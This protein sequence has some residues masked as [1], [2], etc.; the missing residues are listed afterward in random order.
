MKFFLN[1]ILWTYLCLALYAGCSFDNEKYNG[2]IQSDQKVI[3]TTDTNHQRGISIEREAT[4]GENSSVLFGTISKAVSDE[5][6]R[7]YISDNQKKQ[8]HIF[9]PD[10]TYLQ[11]LG[12]EGRGPGEFMFLGE[13][14]IQLKRLYVV[15]SMQFRVNVFSTKTLELIDIYNLHPTNQKEFPELSGLQLNF[16][17]VVNDSTFLVNFSDLRKVRNI[18]QDRYRKYYLVNNKF[19]II[20][21]KILKLPDTPYIT[22]I[23][24]G[25][26][27]AANFTFLGK[28]LLDVTP[29][30]AIFSAWSE[31]FL[32]E[33][34]NLEGE[35]KETIHFPFERNSLSKSNII[36][37][38]SDQSRAEFFKNIDLP[39]NWPAID[40][41]FIDDAYRLWVSIIT[42][43]DEY[44]EWWVIDYE[45]NLIGKFKWPGN[46]HRY[47]REIQHVNNGKMY[48]W[49]I[50]D[51]TG[52]QQI[53]RYRIEFE[54][55]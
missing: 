18:E 49:E 38:L 2:S 30:G 21:D 41:F 44:Y 43:F 46:R 7:V 53:V 20:S 25:R 50:D 52:L 13:I 8:I 45:G 5:A 6:G 32:L 39:D 54:E 55:M 19:E 51:Q 12:K 29:S 42:D 35:L 48:A 22:S 3:N 31:E 23:V 15:D 1:H 26:R 14:S 34:Y 11:S 10:G 33:K 47:S 17:K 24:Q 37:N 27:V 36:D 16:S 40:D 9:E 28:P 4:F